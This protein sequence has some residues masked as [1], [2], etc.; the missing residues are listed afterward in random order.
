[1]VCGHYQTISFAKGKTGK[2]LGHVDGAIRQ[3]IDA[4]GGRPTGGNRICC[5]VH[6]FLQP[7]TKKRFVIPF[8][9]GPVFGTGERLT[10]YELF[11]GV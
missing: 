6:Q 8:E 5:Q 11:I 2:A 7:A 3:E 1:M 4:M 10:V 9:I